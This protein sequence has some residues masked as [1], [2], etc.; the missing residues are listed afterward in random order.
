M[1][2]RSF[3]ALLGSA[4]AWPFAARAQRKIPVIGLL[5][6]AVPDDAE[7]A[8]NLTAFAKAS[9]MP[10]LSRGRTLQSNIAGW[11]ASTSGCRRSRPSS[12][13]TM[14]TSSS[15]KGDCR[16]SWRSRARPR[17]PFHVARSKLFV[18]ERFGKVAL[19]HLDTRVIEDY[20]E[21][22]RFPV[23]GDDEHMGTDDSP[24]CCAHPT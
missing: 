19:S 21:H 24:D 13:P 14:S 18:R 16:R 6:A 5:G 20:I 4:A 17:P 11:R 12:S 2:R 7:A 15:T 8:R 22:T 9:P 1:K 10:D 3:I 23:P